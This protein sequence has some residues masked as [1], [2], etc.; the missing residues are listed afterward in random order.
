MRGGGGGKVGVRYVKDG[1]A[2]W[3]PMVR[4]KGKKSGSGGSSCDLDLMEGHKW[5]IDAS[6]IPGVC[7]HGGNPRVRQ[8]FAVKSSPI[9]SRTRTKFKYK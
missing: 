2:G 4:R 6:G 1:E 3:T 5:S 9:S 7:I 8:W